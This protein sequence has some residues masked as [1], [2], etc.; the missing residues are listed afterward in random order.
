MLYK[1]F[2]MYKILKIAFDKI[3]NP[4]DK[5]F[6]IALLKPMEPSKCMQCIKQ[7]G[8]IIFRDSKGYKLVSC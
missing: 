7:I 3:F 2:H 8:V 1:S 5:L 6:I 4:R